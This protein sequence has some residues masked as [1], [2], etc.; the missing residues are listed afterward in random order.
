MIL[1]NSWA[2]SMG[3]SVPRHSKRP[4]H[5][6]LPGTHEGR[7]CSPARLPTI[8]ASLVNSLPQG[9][10]TYGPTRRKPTW[11]RPILQRASPHRGASETGRT[12][13]RDYEGDRGCDP[14]RETGSTTIRFKNESFTRGLRRAAFPG[15]MRRPLSSGVDT[16][17]QMGEAGCRKCR[18]RLDQR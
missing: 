15:G 7:T 12:G 3:D 10:F 4:R 6:L 14:G 13:R 8:S 17:A 16:L 1:Q 11:S 9:R 18:Q 5:C 2:A